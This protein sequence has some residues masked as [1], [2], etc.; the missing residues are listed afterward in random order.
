MTP[1]ALPSGEEVHQSLVEPG[2]VLDVV[3]CA[4]K[5]LPF[6]GESFLDDVAD[7]LEDSTPS[8]RDDQFGV[9][10]GGKRR[11]RRLR[12]PRSALNDKPLSTLL[13]VGRQWVRQLDLPSGERIEAAEERSKI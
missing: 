2:G 11:E 1:R 7:L 9:R 8:S 5:N 3:T 10:V 13:E 4:G 12:L 6:G